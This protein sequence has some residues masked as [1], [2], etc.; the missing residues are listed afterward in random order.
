M[1]IPWRL[2]GFNFVYFSLFSLFLSFM[3]V[4]GTKA[5]F[6]DTHLGFILGMGSF[7]SIFSQPIWGMVSDRFRTIRKVLLLLISASIIA[8]FLVFQS[9]QLWMYTMMVALMNLFFLG[10]DPLVESLNFQTARHQGISYGSVRMFGALGFAFASLATGYIAGHWGISSLSWIFMSY[11]T[12]TL[13][14]AFGMADVQASAKRPAFHQLRGFFTQSHSL[15]FFLFVLIVAI[16]QKMNDQFIG[17]YMD[18]L[19]GGM[20]LTGLAWFVMTLTETLFF[21]LSARM[22]KAGREVSFMTAAA[23]LYTLRFLLSAW[24]TDPYMLVALQMF[25]G[26]TFVLFYVSGIQYLYT[27]VPEQWKSTGQT[28]FSVMFF[29]VSGI[30]GSTLGGWLMDEY[31]GPALYRTMALFSFIGFLLFWLMFNKRSKQYT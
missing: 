25:Q 27:I 26:V 4:Y 20:R 31:G 21:A 10:T 12:V 28:V 6:S 8:G 24:V 15:T 13:I 19:G 18:R 16:S 29:G 9:E 30:I 22:I 7:I 17:L 1:S 23:A 2:R 5:G 11:G 3:P 14:L